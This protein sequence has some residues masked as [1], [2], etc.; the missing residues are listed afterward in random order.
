MCHLFKSNNFVQI[1]KLEP[2]I[3]TYAATTRHDRTRTCSKT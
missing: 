1:I 2:K 3:S